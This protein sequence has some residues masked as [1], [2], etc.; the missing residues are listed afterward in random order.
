MVCCSIIGLF[1]ENQSKTEALLEKLCKHGPFLSATGRLYFNSEEKG[2]SVSS[3]RKALKS[4][5][6]RD[7]IV[8]E[9]DQNSLPKD[10]D[11]VVYG[12]LIDHITKNATLAY[13]RAN[14]KHLRELSSD[15]DDAITKVDAADPIA[16]K[17][18]GSD[19]EGEMNGSKQ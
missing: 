12:W 4:S 3:V 18:E 2:Y 1:A 11:N 8:S 9:Y 15:L 10:D 5:G 13:E 19:K 14:Q 7:F 16:P 6:F 17:G